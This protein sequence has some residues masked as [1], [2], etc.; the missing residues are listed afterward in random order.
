MGV[1]KGKSKARIMLEALRVEFFSI[2]ALNVTWGTASYSALEALTFA[3]FGW[4]VY[5]RMFRVFLGLVM[6]VHLLSVRF[7][8]RM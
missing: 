6:S 7:L 2:W 3:V 8:W 1:W 4:F 5:M